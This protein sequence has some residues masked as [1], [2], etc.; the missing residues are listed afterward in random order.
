MDAYKKREIIYPKLFE[1]SRKNSIA[2]II[3]THDLL[4]IQDV[5]HVFVLDQGVLVHQGAHKELLEQ[6]AEVYM[7]LLGL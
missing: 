4:S 7:K 1:F 5:D 6:K 3:V 2:L